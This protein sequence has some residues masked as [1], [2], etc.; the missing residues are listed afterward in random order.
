MNN[1]ININENNIEN[2]NKFKKDPGLVPVSEQ[3][4]IILAIERKTSEIEIIIK[5]K[6]EHWFV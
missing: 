6:Q 1:T 4:E 2:D 5:K 3:E